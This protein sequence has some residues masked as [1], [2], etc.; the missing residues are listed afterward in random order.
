MYF[1]RGLKDTIK[2]KIYLKDWLE[3]ISTYMEQ[4]ICINNC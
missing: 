4:A 1:Y 2:D 3:D